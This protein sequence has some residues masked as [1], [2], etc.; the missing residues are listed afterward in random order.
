MF[1]VEK[2]EHWAYFYN[3]FITSSTYLFNYL[4]HLIRIYA[5]IHIY[6]DT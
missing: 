2:V 4:Y 6:V 1:F 3:F 5:F